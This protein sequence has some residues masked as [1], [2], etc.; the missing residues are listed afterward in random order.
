MAD[1]IIDAGTAPAPE[2]KPTGKKAATE[3][4]TEISKLKETMVPK[5]DLEAIQAERD[6][7][8]YALLTGVMTDD[9]E[10]LKSSAELCKE[11]AESIKSGVTNVKGFETALKLRQAVINETGKDPFMTEALTKIDPDFGERVAENL[12]TVLEK[13]EGNPQMFNA[14]LSQNMSG[15]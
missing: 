9:T 8:K 7:L 12:A 5:E 1:E 14:I 4:L 2:V 13:S 15:K 6:K 10:Q 3:F 11:Y